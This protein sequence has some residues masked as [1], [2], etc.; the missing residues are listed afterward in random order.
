MLAWTKASYNATKHIWTFPNGSTLQFGSLNHKGD[1]EEF[2][3]GEFALII[4]SKA[5]GG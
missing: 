4:W 3:G 2:Q 1:E 5:G